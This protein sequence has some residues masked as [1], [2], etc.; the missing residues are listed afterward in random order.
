MSQYDFDKLV[1]KYLAGEASPEEEKLMREW[2]EHMLD[3][4]RISL[5]HSEKQAIK[6]RI[7]N[8]IAVHTLRRSPFWVRYGWAGVSAVAASILLLIT[9]GIFFRSGSFSTTLSRTMVAKKGQQKSK[10]DRIHLENWTDTTRRFTLTDGSLVVLKP[11]SSLSYA[12]TFGAKTR[13]VY[14]QGEA[15]F[16]IKH[17]S[18]R[19]FMVHTGDL[20]TQV[21]GT[22]FTV[23]SYE[24][25]RDIEVMVTRGRVSVYEASAKTPQGRD[26]VILIPNQKITFDKVSQKITPGLI[27]APR[28]ILPPE[29][30]TSFVFDRTPLSQVLNSLRKAYGIDFI[31]ENQALNRCAFTGDINELP[32]YIQLD[33]VCKS[34][35]A[36][37]ERRGTTLFIQ[38][39]GCSE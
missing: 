3:R 31:V 29:S 14:L 27:E 19:P 33:L 7:W 24:E 28:M 34:L 13:Q 15:F 17:D 9:V 39:E 21:L 36:S 4:T 8:R 23:K 25:A 38:G 16:D 32:L 20:V 5:S 35:N 2:S 30:K 1:E 6:T 18:S 22:S 37:Y 10:D 11:K 12:K 26:G